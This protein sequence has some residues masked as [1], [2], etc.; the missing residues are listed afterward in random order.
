MKPVA[1]YV[2]D[3]IEGDECVLFHCQDYNS[4]MQKCMAEMIHRPTADLSIWNSRGEI[5]TLRVPAKR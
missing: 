4:A 1:Y 3:C 2:M 5:L